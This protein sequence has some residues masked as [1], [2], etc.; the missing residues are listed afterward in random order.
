M[1]NKPKK[2]TDVYPQG[3]KMGDEEQRFFIALAR[4]PKFVWRSVSALAKESNLSAERVE[5]II[6]KYHKKNMVLSNPK[7]EGDQWGYWERL[8]KEMWQQDAKSIAQKDQKSRID[9]ATP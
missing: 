1:S 3:T 4:H 2:W 5:E 6:A 8:P 7:G 9:K